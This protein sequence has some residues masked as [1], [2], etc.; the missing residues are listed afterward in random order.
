MTAHHPPGGRSLCGAQIRY[1]IIGEHH[2]AIGSLAA[3]AA[4]WRAGARS[5][6]RL[7]R[8]DAS[9]TAAGGRL[10]QSF[11]DPAG[12]AGQA[13]GRALLGSLA[14]RIA[15]DWQRRYGTAPWLMETYVEAAVEATRSGTV[16]RAANWIEVG[17]TGSRGRQDRAGKGGVPEKR[18][19]LYPL[20]PTVLKRLCGQPAPPLLGWVRRE[21]GGAKLGDRRLED[22]PL[23]LA[24]AFFAKPRA[25]IPQAAA[26]LRRSRP[27]AVFRS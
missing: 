27:P 21:F 26:R 2:G 22:R 6:A 15:G 19:F 9:C 7:G 18:V 16:C 20:S 14:R 12:R 13:S 11:S 3:S 10:Q 4:A 8:C 17:M 5:V 1:L 23:G 24:G 25:N